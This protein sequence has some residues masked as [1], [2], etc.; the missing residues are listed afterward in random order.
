MSLKYEL[1]KKAVKIIGMKNKGKMS[2]DEIID[3]KKSR[4]QRLVSLYSLIPK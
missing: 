1:L 2:A 4:M 3:M